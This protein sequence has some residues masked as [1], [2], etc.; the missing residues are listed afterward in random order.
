MYLKKCLAFG[1]SIFCDPKSTCASRKG[2]DKDCRH[3]SSTKT[4]PAV[5][6]CEIKP[7]K[8]G[9]FHAAVPGQTYTNSPPVR[10]T[11]SDNYLQPD[12]RVDHPI[13]IRSTPQSEA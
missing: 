13:Q 6:M 4:T 3:I 9:E 7:N 1:D 8:E 11:K 12:L 2:Q 10:F 5:S